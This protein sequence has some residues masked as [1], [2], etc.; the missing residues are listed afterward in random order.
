M[1]DHLCCGNSAVVEYYLSSGDESSAGK[2]LSAL[3][4]RKTAED[5]Y[6]FMTYAYHNEP[7]ASL[8]FGMSGVGYEMLRYAFPDKIISVL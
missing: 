3:Y 1:R 5:N 6:R 4:R 2:V 8:F 7:I